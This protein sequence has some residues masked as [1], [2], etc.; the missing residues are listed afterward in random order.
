VSIKMFLFPPLC[1]RCVRRVRHASKAVD[2]A[3]LSLALQRFSFVLF[4]R[5]ADALLGF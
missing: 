1:W 5:S 4:S 2:G 3:P